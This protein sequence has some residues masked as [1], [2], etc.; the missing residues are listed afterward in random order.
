MYIKYSIVRSKPI[1][2]KIINFYAMVF[3]KL[4]VYHSYTV[5]VKNLLSTVQ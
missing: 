2:N 4:L 1:I 3:Y 5:R